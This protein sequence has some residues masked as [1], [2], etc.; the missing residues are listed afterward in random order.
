MTPW[1]FVPTLLPCLWL[2]LWSL[3]LS[4]SAARF[5]IAADA[6]VIPN[7]A[8]LQPFADGVLIRPSLSVFSTRTDQSDN[9]SDGKNNW[10]NGGRVDVEVRKTISF[11]PGSFPTDSKGNDND[12]D[13]YNL[14]AASDY[15]RDA[16]ME[17]HWRKGG[18]LPIVILEKQEKGETNDGGSTGTT[19][20]QGKKRVI[21][22]VFM[23][24]TISSFPLQA[25]E[26][27]DDLAGSDVSRELEY[28]VTSPGP[29]FGPDLVQGSHTG[30]VAFISSYSPAS[31][32]S[33]NDDGVAKAITT[34]LVWKVEFDAIRLRILYQKVTEFTIGTAATTVQ[35]AVAMPRLLT[36]QTRMRLPNDSDSDGDPAHTARKEWLDFLFSTI[37]GGL[38]LPPPIPFGKVLE[39]GGGLARKKLFRFPPGLIETAMVEGPSTAHYVA[40]SDEN[41]D[42][43]DNDDDG[44]TTAYYRLENPGW[45]TFPFLV[46]TH[47][48]RARFHPAFSS[49]AQENATECLVDMTW[50]I[51]LRPYPLA[52]PIVEKLTEMTVSTIARN[53]R[54]KLEDPGAVVAILPHK[55]GN[56]FPLGSVLSATWV[57]RVLEACSNDTRTR[58][59]WEQSVSLL[60]PW[61]WADSGIGRR[62]EDDVEYEWS[63]GGI[64]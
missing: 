38:P 9:D 57:G 28:K 22:P 21:A 64:K 1:V 48:G 24:E 50:E 45:W 2:W 12:H 13:H 36:L 53:L 49:Q 6:F 15:V 5:G 10:T 39:E 18:G 40:V 46:H 37:G 16:W 54:I 59:A 56:S 26:K 31:D 52:A 4:L 7:Q 35:E 32:D 34:T 14:G 17:Y 8:A 3:S 47:L 11:P 60:R 25:Y 19:N 55:G 27:S 51:E 30:K 43:D 23:E 20:A 61:T 42:D 29:F 44:T 63:D 33:D 58:S 62:G 41:D